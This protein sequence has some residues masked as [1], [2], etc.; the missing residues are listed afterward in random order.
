MPGVN[1]NYISI[2]VSVLTTSR[3]ARSSGG[4]ARQGRSPQSATFHTANV[5]DNIKNLHM[6]YIVLILCLF[7]FSCRHQ[8][9][10]SKVISDK[11]ICQIN[12]SL[13]LDNE[14]LLEEIKQLYL[15]DIKLKKY[16]RE[17]NDYENF[18]ALIDNIE[19][20]GSFCM[21]DSS[22]SLEVVIL[23]DKL[24][25]LNFYNSENLNFGFLHKIFNPITLKYADYYKSQSKADL[26]KDLVYLIG[27]T[28]AEGVSYTLFIIGLSESL[29]YENFKSKDYFY[30]VLLTTYG[31]LIY[32]STEKYCAQ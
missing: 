26:S 5:N 24:D 11:I 9:I 16:Y 21:I 13:K 17:N 3:V 19:E 20:D 4:A 1:K 12:E 10:D 23:R 8:T 29:N 15:K 22:L 7:L 2:W 30:T 31:N 27:S 25:K 6:R 32:Y 14:Y 28:S 18:K